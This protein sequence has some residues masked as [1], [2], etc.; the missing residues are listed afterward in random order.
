MA[1]TNAPSVA[2]RIASALPRR[3]ESFEDAPCVGRWYNTDL[4][5]EVGR[6]LHT[7]R[8]VLDYFAHA[9]A[10]CRDCP[11]TEACLTRVAP[12]ES[13][14]D[15][16]CAGIVWRNGK[17]IGSVSGVIPTGRAA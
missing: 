5:P 3:E 11:L 4:P 12:R 17:P 2:Q 15:G 7:R 14:Y 13:F 1:P 9:L 6:E 16:V 8:A 10:M